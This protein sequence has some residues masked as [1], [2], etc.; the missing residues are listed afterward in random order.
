MAATIATRKDAAG[1]IEICS[2][3]HT[4]TQPTAAILLINNGQFKTLKLT[5]LY[6]TS[7]LFIIIDLMKILTE[8][9]DM[10]TVNVW[11]KLRFLKFKLNYYFL[12]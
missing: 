12:I 4:R 2:G 1:D 8:I 10:S 9:V 7:H 11:K 3:Q 5:R 6:W